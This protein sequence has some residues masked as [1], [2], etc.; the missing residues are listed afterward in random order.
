MLTIRLA[1]HGRKKQ[2]FYH[3]VCAEKTRAA[4]KKFV[5]KLGYYNPL[6]NGG[7][8]EISFNAERLQVR[9]SNGAQMSDTAARLLKKAGVEGLDKFIVMKAAKPSRKSIEEAKAKAE[10]EAQKL[11]DEKAAK[12]AAEAEKKAAE[13]AAKAEA[14][15]EAEAPA[16][17]TPADAE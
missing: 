13:E 14:E 17:E 10:A 9:L 16:E 15:Q 6:S 3:I 11:A 4:Q 7:K 1:R 2:P 5:E 8:G 12:E